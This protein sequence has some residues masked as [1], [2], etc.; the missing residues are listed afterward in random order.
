M[1]VL[2]LISCAGLG[3]TACGSSQSP[4]AAAAARS[5]KL[6]QQQRAEALELVSC[7]RQ[8]GIHLPEPDAR[9]NVSTRGVNLKGHRRKA[10]INTCYH[11]VVNKAAKAQEAEHAA[12]EAARKR[13]GEPPPTGVAQ[14]P[15]QKAAVFA[16][17]REQ[18]TEVVSCARRH[19]IHLPEPDAHNNINPRGINLKSHHNNIVMSGCFRQVVNKASKEQ[20]ELAREQEAGPKR[21][22]E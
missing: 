9:N 15:T 8:H 18:L 21:L 6:Y 12:E 14:S 3:L 1:I 17:E 2:L 20:Q 5:N 16:K 11:K 10:T 4:A 7:A 19:G 13:R 22:G